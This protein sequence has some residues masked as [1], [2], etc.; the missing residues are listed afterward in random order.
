[1]SIIVKGTRAL[2]NLALRAHRKSVLAVVAKHHE[3]AELAA[4][5]VAAQQKYV[6]LVQDKVADLT[7]IAYKKKQA[8]KLVESLANAEIK[9]LPER[10][11]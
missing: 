4:L 3:A 1:M 10:V 5:D 9:R 7:E 11:A 6:K 2:L 8:A